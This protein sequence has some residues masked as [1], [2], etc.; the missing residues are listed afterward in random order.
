MG[1]TYHTI[2]NN[3]IYDNLSNGIQV[4]GYPYNSRHW[5]I[6]NNVFAYQY[7]NSGIV[8][9][10]PD[11]T[12][13]VIENNIFF[14]NLRKTGGAG[15]GIT[16]Y[17]CGPRNKVANNVFFRTGGLASQAIL[18]TAG[19]ASYTDLG[20]QLLQIDP[21]FAA[22][23]SSDFRL[24]AGSPA[25]DKGLNLFSQGVTIDFAGNPRPAAGS[26]EIG[27]YEFGSGTSVADAAPGIVRALR[28]R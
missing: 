15:H 23:A 17:Y 18:D 13:N 26:F 25:I 12:D 28:W 24:S 19:G 11:A 1:G 14:E 5:L 10:Q 6:A 22:P 9:W 20:G 21:R 8:V 16:F 3:L 4:A 2:K 27:A 7:N